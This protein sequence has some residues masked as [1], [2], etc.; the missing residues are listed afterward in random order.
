IR[1]YYNGQRGVA[2]AVIEQPGANALDAA[3]LVLQEMKVL[4]K[5]MP[6]GM[7]YATPYNPTEFVAASVNAVEHSLF[8]AVALVVVVVLIFLQTWR[9][10]I[11]PIIAI[12]VTLVGTF[13]V[14]LALGFSINS[15]SLFALV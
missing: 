9:A 15:L 7:S 1:A 6:K 10:A 4:G 5:D 13:A 8:E 2:L 3:E 12:P 11:I 14:Q